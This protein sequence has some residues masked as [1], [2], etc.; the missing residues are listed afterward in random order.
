MASIVDDVRLS[1]RRVGGFDGDQHAA[2]RR[3]VPARRPPPHR[4]DRPARAPPGRRTRA[5]QSATSSPTRRRWIKREAAKKCAPP[6][7]RE[8][9][10]KAPEVMTALKPCWAMS[11]LVVSQVLP[12]DRP[13]FDVVIFD[14]ASQVT[15]AEAIPAMLRGRR[16]VVAGDEQPAAADRLLLRA[17][18]RLDDD[19]DDETLAATGTRLRVD[20]RRA[21]VPRRLRACSSWHYRSQDERLIAFSNAHLYDWSLTDVPGRQR[22]RVPRHVLVPWQP[23][24][25]RRR[26]RAPTPRS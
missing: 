22:A 25:G 11:P 9:F 20:P 15:P 21:R 7:V 1:D 13:Y 8:T 19:E 18:D 4:D 26:G 16:L 23:R 24:S 2:H 14:E 12:A 17:G 6:A 3:R 10:R 5:S